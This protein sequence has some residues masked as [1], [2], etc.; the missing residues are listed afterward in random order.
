MEL[1]LTVSEEE[2]KVLFAVTLYEAGKVLIGSG[3]PVGRLLQCGFI[4]VLGQHKVPIFNYTADD[5]AEELGP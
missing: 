5:L 2:A 3:R 1:P 4:H